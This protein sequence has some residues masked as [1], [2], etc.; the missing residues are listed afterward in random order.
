M[1]IATLDFHILLY[2]AP[3]LFLSSLYGRSIA[4]MYHIGSRPAF[5]LISSPL[6]YIRIFRSLLMK[7]R[8]HFLRII[9]DNPKGIFRYNFIFKFSLIAHMHLLLILCLDVASDHKMIQKVTKMSSDS[10]N[11]K[12]QKV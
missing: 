8:S 10:Q 3:S 9:S 4:S 6:A 11:K 7:V 2:F 5:R 12:S 1:V